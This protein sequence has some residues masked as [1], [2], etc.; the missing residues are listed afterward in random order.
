MRYGSPAFWRFSELEAAVVAGQTLRR[1][2][3][4]RPRDL[5]HHRVW[6]YQQPGLKGRP[7][8]TGRPVTFEVID[9]LLE[10]LVT[11]APRASSPAR[12]TEPDQPLRD[13]IERMA[14]VCRS[15]EP[16][17]RRRITE[18]HESMQRR[19]LIL[20]S[21]GL[22]RIAD[23]ATISSLLYEVGSSWMIGDLA[24][25]LRLED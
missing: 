23:V 14:A 8:P 2:G 4:V 24:D 5:K 3:F 1:T 7:N 18:W 16:A 6:T 22:R 15:R 10:F 9:Q 11:D 17:L 19:E 13:H 25:P 12:T 21:E 20:S